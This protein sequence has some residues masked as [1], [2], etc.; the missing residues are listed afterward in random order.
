MQYAR[1][2]VTSSL[3]L[4]SQGCD[5]DLGRGFN[6]RRGRESEAKLGGRAHEEKCGRMHSFWGR[7]MCG[8]KN[9]KDEKVVMR[10]SKLIACQHRSTKPIGKGR[11]VSLM[12]SNCLAPVLVRNCRLFLPHALP[13]P[14]LLLFNYLLLPLLRI[15]ISRNPTTI[16]SVGLRT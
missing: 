2:G 14:L 7:R 11:K 13:F 12:R 15:S 9:G 3:T 1:F 8:E 4:L 16:S 10:A 5:F 6:R